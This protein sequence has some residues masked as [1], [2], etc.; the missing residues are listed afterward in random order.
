[1][2]K[3]AAVIPLMIRPMNSQARVGAKV[4]NRKSIA[5]PKNEIS[6]TGRLPI[7]SDNMPRIG[8]QKNCISP[9]VTENTTL[10]SDAWAVSPPANCLIRLGS[11]GIM[12]PNDT[13]FIRTQAKMK[14]NAASRPPDLAG[15][16]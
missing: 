15:S 12:I 10:I 3:L 16:D 11:T 6:S 4:M 5:R 14:R 7:R 13:A 9:Q 1:M 2:E 8:P